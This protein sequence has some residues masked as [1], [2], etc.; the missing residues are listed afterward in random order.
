MERTRC[1]M[2]ERTHVGFDKVLK[3]REAK[4]PVELPAKCEVIPSVWRMHCERV[5]ADNRDIVPW[6]RLVIQVQH[7][8]CLKS[9]G[10]GHRGSSLIANCQQKNAQYK[11]GPLL[12]RVH[13]DP[14][15]P[16]ALCITIM[17]RHATYSRM[18]S[19]GCGSSTAV[20]LLSLLHSKPRLSSERK[21]VI[22][23]R[24]AGCTNE[25][26]RGLYQP[27]YTFDSQSCC[28]LSFER[29]FPT[30]SRWRSVGQSPMAQR[31]ESAFAA[32]RSCRW[33]TEG[34]RAPTAS[35]SLSDV[36]STEQRNNDCIPTLPCGM[37]EIA[38]R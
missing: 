24:F 7:I 19:C 26:V 9:E 6:A 11:S 3:K 2:Q 32:A 16:A 21:S 15:D 23:L 31:R 28:R 4:E 20:V 30:A 36:M 29:S 33:L 8:H 34:T 37:K 17:I 35:R 18:R 5:N 14:A 27:R 38:H 13:A 1:K 12:Y 22:T 25:K 10:I